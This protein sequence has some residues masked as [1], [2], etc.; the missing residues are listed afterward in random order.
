VIFSYVALE[1]RVL[2]DHPLR[3]IRCIVDQVLEDLSREFSRMY[4]RAGDRQ[5]VLA[6]TSGEDSLLFVATATGTI[7]GIRAGNAYAGSQTTCA[8]AEDAEAY[9][10]GANN[11]AGTSSPKSG[12]SEGLRTC[13]RGRWSVMRAEDA[14]L[15]I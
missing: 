15:R 10:W 14:P 6:E 3:T 13:T 5:T 11:V 1:D 2:K 9:C 4:A 12:R 8:M 7:V